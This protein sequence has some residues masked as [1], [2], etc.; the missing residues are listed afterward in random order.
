MVWKDN[1]FIEIQPNPYSKEQLDYNKK[2]IE[3]AKAY[4]L[5]WIATTDAHFLKEED[6][7]I[8]K[9]YLNSKDGER[10]ID[11]FYQTCYLMSYDEIKEKLSVNIDIKDV[12]TAL[13]NTNLILNM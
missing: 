8:H 10:E 3:I 1:F 12:E 4:E 11:E 7:E 2:A 6:R 5:N 9:A 13:K